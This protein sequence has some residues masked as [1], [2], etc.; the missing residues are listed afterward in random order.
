M[1][2]EQ[3]AASRQ[4]AIDHTNRS[5][6]NTSKPCCWTC[7]KAT[8]SENAVLFVVV[9]MKERN[10]QKIRSSLSPCAGC[11]RDFSL[12]DPDLLHASD[13]LDPTARG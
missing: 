4:G 8:F 9:P 11:L 6:G 2:N 3:F 1:R 13:A 12:L 5:I 10:K 7:H